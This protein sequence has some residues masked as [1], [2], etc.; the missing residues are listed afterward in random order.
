M[1]VTL[2]TNVLISATFWNGDSNSIIEKIEKKE[3]QLILSKEIL[4]EFAEVLGYDEIQ[5]KMSNK[6]LVMKR[7]VQ[8]I[9]SLSKIVVPKQKIKLIKEDPDDN[10]ILEENFELLVFCC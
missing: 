2:D 5:K 1:K 7:T 10:K 6:K 4:Q 3:L 8:K 9:A